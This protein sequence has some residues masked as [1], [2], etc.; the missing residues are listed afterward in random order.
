MLLAFGAFARLI[1]LFFATA[2]IIVIGFTVGRGMG[3]AAR[4]LIGYAGT[5]LILLAQTYSLR[6]RLP[7][8]ARFGPLK[9]WMACHQLLTLL[10]SALVVVHAGGGDPPRGLALLSF[11]LMLAAVLSG[12]VG[13]W[14]HARA[15]KARSAM[16]SELRKQGLSEADVEDQLFLVTMTE[17]TFR[18][19][20]SIHRPITM[21]FFAT[22]FLH[23]VAM[24]LFGGVFNG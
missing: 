20:R 2:G 10:G 14:I 7:V 18:S 23:V 17:S 8:L 3:D 19:W 9:L 11:L 1:G 24:F 5:I 6:K 15:L 4:H 13:A 21:S 12:L 22:L 16:R